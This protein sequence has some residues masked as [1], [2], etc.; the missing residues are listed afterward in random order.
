M[1]SLAPTENGRVV[2]AGV[3]TVQADTPPSLEYIL[4]LFSD[5]RNYFQGFHNECNKVDDYYYGRNAIPAPEGFAAVRTARSRSIINTATDHVDVNNVS[6]DVP[7]ASLRAKARAEKLKKFYQ[8]A[9]LNIKAPVKRTVVRHTFAY[10]IG[11]LKTMFESMR[12][13]DSPILEDF[14]SET[15]YKD[16]LADFMDKRGVSWP[17][18]VENVN[19]KRLIWDLSKVGPRWVIEFYERPSR[20]IQQRYPH[21]SSKKSGES[22]PASWIEYWDTEWAVYIADNEVVFAEKHGYGFMPFEPVLPANSMDWDDRAPQE[23]YQGL[24]HG[25]FDL[26]DEHARSMTAY[27]AILQSVAWTTVDFSGPANL[28]EQARRNYEL[29]GGKNL[30]PTGVEVRPSPKLPIPPEIL[31]H[32][33][34]VETQLEEATFP[35]VVRGIRPRGVS[36][37]FA[38]SVLAGMGRLVFQGVADGMARTIEQC[39]SNFAKLIENKLRG[40]ITVHA[41]YDVHNFDQ[42]IGPEDI[43]GYYENTASLKA[44]APEEREREA[45][46][47]LR[48]WDRGQGIIS[49]Y[50]AQRRAGVINPFE[51]QLEMAAEA[52][53]ASPTFR[54]IQEQLAAQRMG[55]LSQQAE[56]TESVAAPGLGNEFMGLGALPRVGEGAIQEQRVR[57][58]NEQQSRVFPRGIGGLDILGRALGG[59]PGRAQGMPSGQTV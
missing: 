46:L 29:F 40:R 23:R 28:A 2:I 42:T 48:L 27:S 54:G 20:D 35:N 5:A 57:T 34:M 11:W 18:L 24:L 45:L 30:I 21:W 31:Q 3:D 33:N 39:N 56:A 36:T 49:M 47:A 22:P 1:V 51:M 55:L 44:E 59:A 17:I 50:D 38:V 6:I 8:G 26:L 10:G 53:I 14:D 7:A 37:G 9:W 52:L 12:W 41:R 43:R 13:P 32:L 16:A 15:D 25:S 4:S 19:P 58:R